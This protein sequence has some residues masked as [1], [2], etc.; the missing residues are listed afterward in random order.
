[1]FVDPV[2]EGFVSS[3]ARPRG[4]TTGFIAF[5]YSISEKW[6]ELLKKFAP[7]T[8]RIAVLRDPAL[9]ASIGQFAAIQTAASSSGRRQSNIRALPTKSSA[10]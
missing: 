3:L 8:T 5:E 6:L 7:Q 10:V 1:M 2:G 9:T 4:N